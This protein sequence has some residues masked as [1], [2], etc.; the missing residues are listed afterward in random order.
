MSEERVKELFHALSGITP[1]EWM[2]VKATVDRYFD[3]KTNEMKRQ[4]HLAGSDE[5]MELYRSIR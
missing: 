5:L 1:A 4:L 3:N 2:W